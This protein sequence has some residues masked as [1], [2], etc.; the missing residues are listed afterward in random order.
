M[1]LGWVAGVRWWVSF[2]VV[3]A[4]VVLWGVPAL[5]ESGS[6][7]DSETVVPSGQDALR[8]DCEALWEFYTVLDDP[9]ILDDL[10]S[11]S[12][13]A[14]PYDNRFDREVTGRRWGPGIPLSE[15][16]GVGV[17]NGRVY[18]L[19]LENAGLSGEIS[20]ALG[21]LSE[22]K[23]LRLGYSWNLYYFLSDNPDGSSDELRGSIPPELAGLTNLRELVLSGMSG[24]IPP[25][26]GQLTSLQVLGLDNHQFSGSIPPELGN[27]SNLRWLSLAGRWF[28]YGGASSSGGCSLVDCRGRGGCASCVVVVA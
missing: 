7:C 28:E 4:V 27:L 10:E 9:G 19:A 22:L 13:Y 1:R 6:P 21:R 12:G 3:A 17:E 11:Y 2:A 16:F 25:V 15:W 20:P 18:F 14:S 8:A 24:S 5:T 23:Y 26:L